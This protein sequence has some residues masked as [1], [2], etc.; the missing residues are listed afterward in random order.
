MARKSLVPAQGMFIIQ[1]S[2]ITCPF[3]VQIFI[4]CELLKGKKKPLD[5]CVFG[6]PHSALTLPCPITP[7]PLLPVCHAL[8]LALEPPHLTLPPRRPTADTQSQKTRKAI[9][10]SAQLIKQVEFSNDGLI[11]LQALYGDVIHFGEQPPSTSY[12]PGKCL[13]IS[14]QLQANVSGGNL[15]CPAGSGES[16]PLHKR[17][18]DVPNPN[19]SEKK[20]VIRN[21]LTITYWFD[22][23]LHYNTYSDSDPIIIP[24]Q[25]HQIE[26]VQDNG[27]YP[28]LL[29]IATQYYPEWLDLLP[30]P[31]DEDFELIGENWDDANQFNYRIT[32]RF[33]PHLDSQGNKVYPVPM[34]PEGVLSEPRFVVYERQL[35]AEDRKAKKQLLIGM[36]AASVVLVSA[37]QLGGVIDVTTWPILSLLFGSKSQPQSATTTTSTTT[38]PTTSSNPTTQSQQ[39]QQE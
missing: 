4:K 25:D 1:K 22:G 7:H 19:G 36:S 29:E 8:P 11:I 13:D 18:V 31:D 10:N 14:M 33:F 26:M 2:P 16:T 17:L 21:R 35:R 32:P 28:D 3:I 12:R 5:L 39:Q 24:L 34:R 23:H 30:S 37:L 15:V 20:H 6:Q 27:E 38:K 9:E